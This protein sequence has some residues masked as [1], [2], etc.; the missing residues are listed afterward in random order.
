MKTPFSAWLFAKTSDAATC[1]PRETDGKRFHE[2]VGPQGKACW[3]ACCPIHPIQTHTSKRLRECLFY[4]SVDVQ[5]LAYTFSSSSCNANSAAQTTSDSAFLSIWTLS[6]P[7]PLGI[8]A[9]VSALTSLERKYPCPP[10]A[11]AIT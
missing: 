7:P 5:F 9:A 6:S 2:V 10:F 4:R 11:D 3:Y 8:S 1:R